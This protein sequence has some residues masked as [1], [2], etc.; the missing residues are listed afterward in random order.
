MTYRHSTPIDDVIQAAIDEGPVGTD[1]EV[2]IAETDVVI[3]G[4]GY[5]GSVAA[6]TVAGLEKDDARIGV[7]VLERGKEYV[8]GDFPNTLGELPGFVRFRRPAD[9]HPTG[10][11]DALFDF[12]L[13]KDVDVLVASGL[14]GG[15]LINANV[16][17]TPD[18]TVFD[19]HWPEAFR[20]GT[21]RESYEKA[22]TWLGASESAEPGDTPKYRALDTLGRSLGSQLGARPASIT[23]KQ[24][25][26]SP[27]EAGVVQP[28][29]TRC[30]NCVTGC[31]VGAK[32][33]L[34]TNLIP[35]AKERGAEFFTG[36]NVLTVTHAP[37]GSGKKWR[38][39]IQRTD[40]I[41]T[42]L[43]NE[44]FFVDADVVI[45]AAGAL[46]ST[47]ILERSREM[48]DGPGLSDRL[49]QR[50][51]TNGDWLG[52]SFGQVGEVGALGTHRYWEQGVGPGPTITGIIQ[53]TLDPGGASHRFTL[54]DAAIPASLVKLYGELTTTAAALH[55]IGDNRLPGW[56]ARHGEPDPLDPAYDP[57][58]FN[59]EILPHGQT[60]L[61]MG[62]DKALRTLG[63]SRVPASLRVGDAFGGL[64]HRQIEVC[65]LSE[66]QRKVADAGLEA[67]HRALSSQSHSAGFDRGQYVPNPLWKLLP[68]SARGALSGALPEGRHLS[69]H[70]LGGCAMGR[71]GGHAV[72]SE[73]CQVFSGNGAECHKGLYVMDGAVVPGPLATNP[74]LTIAAIAWHA[75]EGLVGELVARD[76]WTIPPERAEKVQLELPRVEPPPPP[77]AEAASS[78]KL[79]LKEQM[80]GELIGSDSEADAVHEMLFGHEDPEKMAKKNLFAAQGVILRFELAALDPHGQF[81]SR[82]KGPT[83]IPGKVELYWN[84]EAGDTALKRKRYGAPPGLNAKEHTVATGSAEV[85]LLE[86]DPPGT[87]A[88]MKKRAKEARKA[89]YTRRERLWRS[90]LRYSWKCLKKEVTVA[91][92][93]ASSK[94]FGKVAEMHAHYRRFTYDVKL[95]SNVGR[96]PITLTGTKTIQWRP[97]KRRLWD[98]LLE[99]DVDEVRIGPDDEGREVRVPARFRVDASYMLDKGLI[100]VQPGSNMV[101]AM[102][103]TLGFL[104]WMA[105]CFLQTSFWEFGAPAYPKAEKRVDHRP[106]PLWLGWLRLRKVKPVRIPL[107]VDDE[108]LGQITLEL[109]RYPQRDPGKRGAEPVLLVHGLAQGSGIFNTRRMRHNMARY[110]WEK[111]Y[112]VWLLDHRLSNRLAIPFGEFGIDAIGRHDIPSAVRLVYERC[113]NQPL[114]IFAHCVGAVGVQMAILRG[115]LKT[116]SG[117]SMVDS[118]CFNAIH[119][120]IVA[121]P[122]NLVRMKLGAFARAWIPMDLLDPA[123]RPADALRPA[124]AMLDR[125]AFSFSRIGETG[126]RGDERHRGKARGH[127]G[128]CD[129]MTFFY[130]RMWRHENLEPSVHR[131]W[132]ELVGRAPGEVYQQLHS[133]LERGRILDDEGNNAYLTQENVQAHWADIPTLFLHGD[134]SDV[135]NPQSA[136]QSAVWLE[137]ALQSSGVPAPG[138]VYLRRIPGFG[139][140]DPILARTAHVEAF[141]LVD[142]FFRNGRPRETQGDFDLVGKEHADAE[143]DQD[144]ETG[145]AVRGAWLTD[146][147]TIAVRYWF[148][149]FR[150]NTV[151]GA[152]R[153]RA[154]W[155]NDPVQIWLCG[156][157][158][159]FH[160]LD[161]ESDADGYVVPRFV[162]RDRAVG[163]ELEMLP[164]RIELGEF[165]GLSDEE[166]DRRIDS[167]ITGSVEPDPPP[168]YRRL[169]DR[170][171]GKDGAEDSF[172]FL[173]GSC[174]Y[175]GVPVERENADGV[176][177]G[178]LK[179]AEDP[180]RSLDLAFF[181]GDQI[182]ADA[183]ADAF[184]DDDWRERYHRN[185]SKAFG[186]EN[187]AKLLRALP[188][189]FAVDDHEIV[190]NYSGGSRTHLQSRPR[191]SRGPQDL[192]PA[193]ITG[194]Q[195]S[196][197]LKAARSYMSSAREKAPVGR[198]SQPPQGSLWYELDHGR[199]VNFPCIV[200]DTRTERT[201]RYAHLHGAG[202]RRPAMMGDAQLAGLLAWLRKA[203]AEAEDR[204]KFIFAGQVVVPVANELV[205]HGNL[206]RA[207]EGFLGYPDTLRVIIDHIV[208]DRIRN[209]VFVGGDLHFSCVAELELELDEHEPVTAWQIVSSGLYAPM[210]FANANP[211][212]Y[213]WWHDTLDWVETKPACRPRDATV[214]YRAE[215]VT[216]CPAHFVEVRVEPAARGSGLDWLV[217]VSA[218]D[219]MGEKLPRPHRLPEPQTGNMQVQLV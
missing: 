128:I 8:P 157:S 178:M 100:Q 197:S 206:F 193:L 114:K 121:S 57:L 201:L 70:P 180:V 188:V 163:P 24:G 32:N 31:N 167:L 49:G 171:E 196:F 147:G 158:R 165:A 214:R 39:R 96:V 95:E 186:S 98:S 10:N 36:A 210:P 17:V 91:E 198:A 22:R 26:R 59:P 89:F 108:R 195:V 204:P 203:H 7:M 150:F 133:L 202:N 125:M 28:P 45:L 208:K 160:W 73:D 174:R 1:D 34:T 90:F 149:T 79:V 131:N 99:L 217:Q 138:P 122:A 40:S 56:F 5:G 80:I 29:C 155:K 85:T 106:P 93:L 173:V 65:K 46:G 175:P 187:M 130:G 166:A 25:D 15:S 142:D 63:L 209:V 110:L 140:M 154:P 216:T 120:W 119:P 94:G 61:V 172:N 51:S 146:R 126:A 218:Y 136:T 113:D 182:Y 151:P 33:T 12:H 21:M 74:F 135:F 20:N 189:H 107:P 176:F 48:E 71:D 109:I 81:A 139:H 132:H 190:D 83:R 137:Q 185:Y 97:G 124:I 11:P 168:W 152:P 50:F 103:S 104:G 205:A 115:A 68:E 77:A 84:P 18:G 44:H 62:D 37:C 13:G 184:D 134:E 38:L 41:R 117:A 75:S 16:A 86:L 116:L 161:V 200:L 170:L 23:V 3:V 35:L 78:A 148:E 191:S 145:H 55:R 6:N 92:V 82:E 129:R 179:H 54:E 69:V 207:S 169:A 66:W 60:L 30:G 183:Y 143:I 102:M 14:G 212:A 127:H 144:L 192:T 43:E 199:E 27:N 52:F 53:G 211:A 42:P 87:E 213:T 58:A 76:G 177:A 194:D 2:V 153:P 162:H 47:E 9:P 67:V 101:E 111:G 123:L 141:P 72:V 156:V 88:E 4:S 164:A 112:D 64:M 181:L 105:R 118:V 159:W 219:R 215:V 19:E